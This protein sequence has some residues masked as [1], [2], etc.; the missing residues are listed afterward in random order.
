MWRV[1]RHIGMGGDQIV[2]AIAGDA[3]ER[4]HGDTLRDASRDEF[5][6]LC[7]EL[8]GKKKE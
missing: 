5:R 6:K 4:E 3:V 1:H 8:E 2:S 7:A